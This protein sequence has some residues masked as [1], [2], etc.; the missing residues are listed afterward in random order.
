MPTHLILDTD[1]HPNEKH[2]GRNQSQFTTRYQLRKGYS[3]RQNKDYT[4]IHHRNSNEMR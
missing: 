4:F 1:F 3:G 2:I